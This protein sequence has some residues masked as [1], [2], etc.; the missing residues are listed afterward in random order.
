MEGIILGPVLL[1]LNWVAQIALRHMK[2]STSRILLGT[3]VAL[4]P[5][6]LLFALKVS[7]PIIYRDCGRSVRDWI[8]CV[9]FIE[10]DG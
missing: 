1:G 3:V 5:G 7:A 10:P 2:P 8:M 9:F 6:L 4:V